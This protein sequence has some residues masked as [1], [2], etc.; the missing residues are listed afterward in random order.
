MLS[1][2]VRL[3]DGTQW[4]DAG[5]DDFLFVPEGGIHGFSNDSDEP[6]SMLILFTPGAPR[7]DYFETLASLARGLHHGPTRSGPRSCSGTTPTGS[8]EARVSASA[9]DDGRAV[10]RPDTIAPWIDAVSR[11]SPQ[12]NSPS[13]RSTGWR[14]SRP[15]GIATSASAIAYVATCSQSSVGSRRRF[16]PADA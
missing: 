13:P 14:R 5:T 16:G 8:D 6:A 3:Y 15:G 7:E 9:R 12:T 10:R 11:W 4:V 1:G 2:S